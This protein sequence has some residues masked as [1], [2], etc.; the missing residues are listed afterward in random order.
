M[1]QTLSKTETQDFIKQYYRNPHN[2]RFEQMIQECKQSIIQSIVVPFRLGKI[3]AAYDKVGGNVDTIHN[4][5]KGIYATKKEQENYKQRGEYDSDKYHSHSKYI[6]INKKQTEL[7]ESG[8]LKDYMTNEKVAKNAKTDLDHIVSAKEIHDDPGR[9]LAEIDGAELANTETNL[10]MTDSAINR[11]KK[12]DSMESFLKKCDERLQKIEKLRNKENLTQSEEKELRKLEKLQKIDKQKAM[13]A[14]KQAR[15]EINAKINKE[16]YTSKKFVFN[17]A[18]T[19]VNEGYKMGMQQALG[20]VIVEFFT[21]VLEEVEDIFK[22]GFYTCENFFES[23]KIRLKKIAD[24]VKQALIGKYKEIVKSFGDGFM[25]GILSNLTTT[26]INIFATTSARL[27]RIIREGIFS[28]FKAI[29]LVLFPPENLT[30]EQVWYEAKKLIVSAII[31]GLGV[32]IEQG[33]EAFL[34]SLGLGSFAN[35]LT[36]VFIGVLTGISLAMAMYWLD[37][38]QKSIEQMRYEAI[39]KLCAENL[40]QLIEERKEIEKLIESTH[41]ERLIT[42]ESSFA[43]CAIAMKNNDDVAYTK[44]LQEINKLWGAELKIKT[45]D[46]VKEILQQPN[47]TGCLEW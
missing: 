40:P 12:A 25:S 27:V 45:I 7:K 19:S 33:I 46:D 28:F 47:R 44:A 35:V 6:E 21:A 13:E 26:I 5:R 3:L 1:A 22:K 8:Q 38:N 42:L 14:D 20:I 10:K 15:D 17:S 31:V 30:Q 39:S 43:D 34:I 2:A 29:K 41:K 11:S 32:L 37:T 16:Y 23:L 36:S 24:K 9:V 18:R 4:A